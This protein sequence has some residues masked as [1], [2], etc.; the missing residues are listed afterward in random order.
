MTGAG[1]LSSKMLTKFFQDLL[2]TS[3]DHQNP[4]N[5]DIFSLK[6]LFL[7]VGEEVYIVFD[8]CVVQCTQQ[9]FMK[10]CNIVLT[11]NIDPFFFLIKEKSKMNFPKFELRL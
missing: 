11:N 6:H 2:S 9:I 7:D 5:C 4:L 10:F 8:F 1:L 3:S